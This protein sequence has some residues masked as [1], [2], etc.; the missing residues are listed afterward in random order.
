[1]G[2]VLLAPDLVDRDLIFR[3]ILLRGES[4]LHDTRRAH[5]SSEQE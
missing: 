2:E 4:A 3:A 5:A 1:M